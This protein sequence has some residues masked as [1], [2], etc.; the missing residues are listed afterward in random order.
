MNALQ[1]IGR[2]AKRLGYRA[3][4]IKENYGFQDFA[5]GAGAA[6]VA[7]MAVF[8]QTPPS[9]RSA[10]FGVGERVVSPW[11]DHLGREGAFELHGARPGCVE[12]S[13]LDVRVHFT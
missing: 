9:Y 8:T 12:G 11:G 7:A 6:R 13:L 3:D 2:A 5:P 4:A 1:Q 10:A